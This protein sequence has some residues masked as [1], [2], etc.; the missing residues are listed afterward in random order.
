MPNLLS[1]T[2]LFPLIGALAV[3]GTPASLRVLIRIIAI[4]STGLSLACGVAVFCLF[5]S[6]TPGY[7]FKEALTWVEALGIQ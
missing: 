7:Q 3:A 1:F 2:I 5:D 6:A 4:A